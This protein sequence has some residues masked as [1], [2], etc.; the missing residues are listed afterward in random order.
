VDIFDIVGKNFWLI[1]LGFSAYN[2]IVNTRRLDAAPAYDEGARREAKAFLRGF[3]MASAI[4]WLVMGVGQ[5]FGGIPTVWHY[6]RPQD[7]NPYVWAF[8]GAIFLE[9][10]LF[11]YWVHFRSGASRIVNNRLFDLTGMRGNFQWSER[12]VKL[13]A[14]VGP[15]FVM[16]WVLLLVFMDAPLPK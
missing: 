8:I 15:V 12:R 2:F 1:C 14:A 13:M 5:L 10:L 16:L 9:S 7:G 6:F 4:P 3:A 11:A